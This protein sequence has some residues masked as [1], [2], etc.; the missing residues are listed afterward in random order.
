MSTTIHNYTAEAKPLYTC[1]L[2]LNINDAPKLDESFFVGRRDDLLFL[3]DALL[4]RSSTDHDQR[5]AIISG[6]GGMGKTQLAI[7]FAQQNKSEYT[8]IV[9][10]DANSETT[11][12]QSI[13]RFAVRLRPKSAESQGSAQEQE[14]QRISDFRAWLSD[15]E[16]SKWLLI[17]DNH[18][19][20]KIGSQSNSDAYNVKQYFPHSA[21]GSILITTRSSKLIYGKMLKL[22]TLNE[23]HSEQI[24]LLRS[25]RSGAAGGLFS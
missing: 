9:W 20:P 21:Q 7:T 23:D 15:V 13:A 6:L 16:N 11:L 24:L 14:E 25:A 18:D 5:I 2:G 8:T 1:G 10:L 22:K 19:N 4:P 12:R 3:K 17:F